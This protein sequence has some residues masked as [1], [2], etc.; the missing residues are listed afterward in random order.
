MPEMPFPDLIIKTTSACN[1]SCDYCYIQ[2]YNNGISNKVMPL[3][4][5]TKIIKDY[6]QLA[7]DFG[8]ADEEENTLYLFWHG[9]EPTLAGKTYFTEVLNIEKY[10]ST[11]PHNIKNGIVTNAISLD[12]DWV[13]FLKEND[14]MVSV[15][16]DGPEQIHNL[17]RKYPNGNGSFNEVM[18]SL[19]L[20]QE[21]DVPFGLLNVITKDLAAQPQ[22]F[23]DFLISQNLQDIALI[24][25]QKSD[26]FLLP[27]DWADFMISLFD[28][29]F[30][31]DN[32]KFHIR[33]FTNIISG[34]FDRPKTLCEYNNCLI[35][36]LCIDTNGDVYICDMFIG[37]S[38]M[39]LGN[40][41]ETNFKDLLESDKYIYLQN[42][43][44]NHHEECLSCEYFRICGGGCFYRRF[45]SPHG[46][47]GKD[48]YCAARKKLIS[49]ILQKIITSAKT[50]KVT[51]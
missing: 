9:G 15:S 27:N 11:S 7:T 24:P 23:F 3:K 29:W 30:D 26:D 39:L 8:T 12:I 42:A 38:N 51:L 46:I 35:N 33:D 18:R 28:L 31:L 6:T 5:T 44:K 22:L 20:L 1:L 13:N 41:T 32:P 48:I 16:L 50:E 43:T 21:Y 49:H 34:I 40:I 47:A 36:H 14:F 17:H 4:I 19:K 25:Y 2:S 37:N 45:I 10:F